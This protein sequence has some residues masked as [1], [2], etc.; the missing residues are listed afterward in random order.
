MCGGDIS[1]EYGSFASGFEIFSGDRSV[2]D[3]FFSRVSGRISL[4]PHL[5]T[6]RYWQVSTN[7]LQFE[8]R[9]LISLDFATTT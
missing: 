9:I 3:K 7:T 2:I 1:F 5:S 6:Q 8:V 4:L